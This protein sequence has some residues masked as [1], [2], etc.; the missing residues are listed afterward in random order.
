MKN[1][2]IIFSQFSSMCKILEKELAHYNPLLIIGETPSQERQRIV[3]LFNKDNDYLILIGTEAIGLGLNLQVASYVVNYDLPWSAA[4]YEQRIG[5]SHR[6]GQDKPVTV[7]NLIA[8]KTI[9]EYCLKVLKKKY[10]IS[11]DVLF[12][13]DRLEKAGLTEEDIKIILNL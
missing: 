1:K 12:D 7:Y 5:R 3:N 9:D 2:V 11:N 8:R 6:I 10:S 13:D 4:K